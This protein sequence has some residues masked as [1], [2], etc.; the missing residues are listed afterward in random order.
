MK[1]GI[2]NLTQLPW[3]VR[4]AIENLEVAIQSGWGIQHKGD[5]SHNAITGTSTTMSGDVTVGGLFR[6]GTTLWG[7]RG[8][9]VVPDQ[10]T[11]SV[12]DYAPRGIDAAWELRLSSDASRTIT[13][14]AAPTSN[15]VGHYKFLYLRNGGSND[16]VL[17]H[18]DSSSAS[19][20][21]FSCPG[22]TNFTLNTADSVWVHYD[23]RLANWIVEGA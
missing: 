6:W 1:L 9:V 16:I 23:T 8:G 4:N 17:S 13:G 2:D 15:A 20:N 18:N 22:G 12:N 21:R 7:D 10:L 19:A 14:M 3:D 5:G 11:A